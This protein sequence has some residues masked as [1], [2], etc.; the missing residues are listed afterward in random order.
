VPCCATLLTGR[1]GRTGP[2]LCYRMYPEAALSAFA[3]HVAPE[4]ARCDLA[5][6]LLAAKALGLRDL[7]Q[8]P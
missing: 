6:V 5:P 2:G 1:A 3:A 4:A 7:R 8:F